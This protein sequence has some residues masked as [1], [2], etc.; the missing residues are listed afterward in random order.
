MGRIPPPFRY[1]RLK[2]QAPWL[3][4]RLS[5]KPALFLR[6]PK[7]LLGL[8]RSQFDTYFGTLSVAQIL[9]EVQLVLQQN[10]VFEET[11]YLN[12]IAADKGYRLLTLSDTSRWV[13]RA[14]EKP[15]HYIHLH[16][17]RYSPFSQR[18]KA[19]VYKLIIFCLAWEQFYGHWPFLDEQNKF[20]VSL[21]LPPLSV[22]H[23]I[24]P[25]HPLIIHFKILS[26][27]FSNFRT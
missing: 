12:W 20:R 4:E 26:L 24:Q 13:L 11:R 8:G 7:L 5:R 3:A 14:G 22:K 9:Q 25:Q 19:S 6:W 16:P 18:I 23:E 15:G 27:P 1:N 10:E 2:H 21:N 17:A